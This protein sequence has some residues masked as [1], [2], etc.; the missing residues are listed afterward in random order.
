M[1]LFLTVF[2]L[3]TIS[4][5]VD[6]A[7]D[8]NLYTHG[9]FHRFIRDD[10]YVT[11]ATAVSLLTS[12][13]GLLFTAVPNEIFRLIVRDIFFNKMNTLIPFFYSVSAAAFF[14]SLTALN[15]YSQR[16]IKTY[17]S[18]FSRPQSRCGSRNDNF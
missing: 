4:Q 10:Q 15:Y 9:L 8:P 13:L 11:V 5:N 17:E 16:V 3:F 12:A 2:V 1:T 7:K 14:I 18:N 6:I